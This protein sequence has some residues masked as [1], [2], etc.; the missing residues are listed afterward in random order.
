MLT[1]LDIFPI[2]VSGWEVCKI[3]EVEMLGQWPVHFKDMFEWRFFWY[4]KETNKVRLKFLVNICTLF[5]FV[6][7]LQMR[8]IWNEEFGL[9]YVLAQGQKRRKYHLKIPLVSS[10]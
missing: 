8:D 10:R 2:L 1:N 6:V 5:K 3:C 4:G 9:K 7:E